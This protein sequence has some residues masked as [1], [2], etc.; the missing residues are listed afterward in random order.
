MAKCLNLERKK[1]K[2]LG[3]YVL[4]TSTFGQYQHS[5]RCRYGHVIR[6]FELE[7]DKKVQ[8]F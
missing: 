3:F 2:H 6:V 7:Y 1:K 8:G 4:I 5:D